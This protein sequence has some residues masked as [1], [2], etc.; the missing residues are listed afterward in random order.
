MADLKIDKNRYTVDSLYQWDKNQELKIYGLSMTDPEIHFTNE[1][2]GGSIVVDCT[3]DESGVISVNIPNSLLQHKY[4]I[5][6]YV[7]GFEGDTFKT[8]HKVTIPVKAR[9]RPGDY[10]L[11]LSDNEVY[12]FQA[13]ERRIADIEAEIQSEGSILYSYTYNADEVKLVE[14]SGKKSIGEYIPLVSSSLKAVKGLSDKFKTMIDANTKLG[15]TAL[16]IAKG[17]NSAKVFDTTEDMEAWLSDEANKGKCTVGNNLYIVAL[18]V[19]DWWISEVLETPDSETGFYYKI[20]QLETQKVDL[21]DITEG[22]DNLENDV[23]TLEESIS[24]DISPRVETLENNVDVLMKKPDYICPLFQEEVTAKTGGIYPALPY[25]FHQGCAVKYRGELHI[26]GGNNYPMAHQKF[27]GTTWE[28]ASTLPY[29]TAYNPMAVVLNDE[30]HLFGSANSGRYK[31]HWKFD[32]TSWTQ[33]SDLPVG[34]YGLGYCVCNNEIH[35]VFLT[36]HLVYNGETWATYNLSVDFGSDALLCVLDDDIH[37]VNMRTNGKHY[38]LNGTTLT[39]VSTP[40][41]VASG[42]CIFV[43]NHKIYIVGGSSHTSD[44][45]VYD[46]TSWK[47]TLLCNGDY[48]FVNGSLFYDKGIITLIGGSNTKNNTYNLEFGTRL[49]GYV[50]ENQNIYLPYQTEACSDNL[51]VIDDGYEVTEDGFVDIL[52]S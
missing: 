25:E 51:K 38:T 4:S 6:V 46:G 19:P 52:I 15:D 33:L 22:I 47:V 30:I 12:S 29:D 39:Q 2:M 11:T 45:Q 44:A 26:L 35:V 32:G 20:A 5:V 17:I 18:E 7:A 42:A 43:A 3:V 27:N 23:E 28:K 13:M 21:T 37:V 34:V 41:Y 31:K 9:K 50:K 8:Y 16:S 14:A 49:R 1:A 10:T 36:Y 24:E 48:N 40:N